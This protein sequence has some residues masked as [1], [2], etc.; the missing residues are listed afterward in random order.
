M[1]K[2]SWKSGAYCLLLG[3]LSIVIFLSRIGLSSQSGYGDVNTSS[4]L[5]CHADLK[6]MRLMGYPEY[7]IAGD[8]VVAQET[9]MIYSGSCISP[10]RCS[11]CH[12]GNPWDFTIDGAHKGLLSTLVMINKERIIK[13]RSQLSRGEQKQLKGLIPKGVWDISMK[14]KYWDEGKK[15]WEGDPSLYFILWHDHNVETGAYNPIIAKRTCGF[16]HLHE[17]SSFASSP[18]GAGEFK[19]GERETVTQPQY[20]DW[21]ADTGPH[22]CGIWVGKLAELDFARFDDEN[23]QLSNRGMTKEITRKM[24]AVTQRNCNKCHVGCLDCHYYP[25]TNAPLKAPKEPSKDH[26]DNVYGDPQKT[27]G[28]THRMLRYPTVQSCM[29]GARGYAC[30]SGP[31]ERRRGDGYVRGSLA[32]PPWDK[33]AADRYKDI[34]YVRGLQCTDCHQ[35]DFEENGHSA[36]VRDPFPEACMKCH[37]AQVK[38]WKKGEHR[39]VRCES[40]HTPVVFGYGWN[41]WVPGQERGIKTTIARH[42]AYQKD[43]INPILLPDPEGLWAPYNPI[44]H[45]AANIRPELFKSSRLAKQKGMVVFRSATNRHGKDL[46]MNGAKIARAYRSSDAFVLG[47][48][49]KSRVNEE[50]EG[51]VMS[52]IALEK[53]AHLTSGLT[54][55]ARDCR[56]CHTPSGVQHAE[57]N[58]RWAAPPKSMY[59]DVHH[60]TY[61]IIADDKGIRLQGLVAFDD[62]DRPAKGLSDKENVFKSLSRDF[63]I[64]PVKEEKLSS[65]E[66]DLDIFQ[67][68]AALAQ[69]IVRAAT[70]R[71]KEFLLEIADLLEEAK[72]EAFHG[73][74]K[75]GIILLNKVISMRK[76]L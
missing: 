57:A 29:G 72:A 61:Q 62:K 28:G 51:H 76:K 45:I 59:E 12:L 11:S 70:I 22:S 13:R 65:Y 58:F 49:Y 36:L 41:F 18:M 9:A 4:C 60:G 27:Y 31:L 15:K 46:D 21:L 47:D 10:P 26:L 43:K 44:P 69:R 52:W 35:P 38:A 63:R 74:I 40:C 16:C 50:N 14:P 53:V 6:K 2:V 25:G 17:T 71:K 67:K 66:K 54:H 8:H 5:A 33:E 20:T 55:K 23:R 32:M 75:K 73:S 7:Y 37:P 56:N 19:K 34:H 3:I 42:S 48:F 24:M 64:K 1:L 68:K 30:H 39:N